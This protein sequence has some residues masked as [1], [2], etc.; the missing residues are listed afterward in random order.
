M[1]DL[2][3]LALYNSHMLKY[4]PVPISAHDAILGADFNKNFA[5]IM[6]G[7][8]KPFLTLGWEVDLSKTTWERVVANCINHAVWVGAGKN[9]VDVKTPLADIDVKSQSVDTLGSITTEAS[10]LQNNKRKNDHFM[11]LFESN[12]FQAL[13]EMFVDL[14]L[15]KV[16]G[17]SNLHLLAIIREKK[18]KT[19]SY[20]LLKLEDDGLTEADFISKMQIAGERSVD[21]PMIDSV[22]GKTYIYISKRRLEIRLNTQGL[23][24]YIVYSH[25]V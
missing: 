8:Y 20:C 9:V 7:F 14:W 12:D 17:T 2:G 21:V 23:K 11:K 1:V 16:T 24:D 13:K 19:V 25:T 3:G 15:D 18:H 6:Q 5:N 10:F 22:Y 4:I